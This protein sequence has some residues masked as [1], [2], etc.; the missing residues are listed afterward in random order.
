MK[1]ATC[2]QGETRLGTTTVTLERGGMT[3]VI[4]ADMQRPAQKPALSQVLFAS[5]LLTLAM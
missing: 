1:C 3:L 5:A 2:K 4:A